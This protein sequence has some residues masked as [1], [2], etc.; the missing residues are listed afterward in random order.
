MWQSKCIIKSYL[1]YS[2][3]SCHYFVNINSHIGLDSWE[4]KIYIILPLLVL[5][6]LSLNQV[7][8]QLFEI[9]HFLALK[10]HGVTSLRRSQFSMT[11]RNSI[12]FKP[13]NFTSE[14]LSSLKSDFILALLVLSNKVKQHNCYPQRRISLWACQEFQTPKL[15]QLCFQHAK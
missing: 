14:S 13:Q 4:K 6:L 9:Q 15:L 5:L 1:L 8:N 2:L 10:Q 3:H 12:N 7:H 11:R